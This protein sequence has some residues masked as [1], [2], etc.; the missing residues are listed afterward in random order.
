MAGFNACTSTAWNG[1]E[2]P[3]C[4]TRSELRAVSEDCLKYYVC[5]DCGKEVKRY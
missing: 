5:P 4:E 2:C 3:N 1:G